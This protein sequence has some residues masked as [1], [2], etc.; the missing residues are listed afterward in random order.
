MIKYIRVSLLSFLLC[1]TLVGCGSNNI[2]EVS[3]DMTDSFNYSESS[4]NYA[5]LNM[6]NAASGVMENDY[7]FYDNN[8]E[9]EM[10]ETAEIKNITDENKVSSKLIRTINLSY[11][12]E[13]NNIQQ[14]M[15]SM[16]EKTK[17][18]GGYAQDNSVNQYNS[19]VN[20]SLVLRIPNDKADEFLN[21]VNGTKL[22]LK[23]KSDNQEDVTLTWSE[24]DTKI[25]VLEAQRDKYLSYIDNASSVEEILAVD[26]KLQK[27]ITD[28][29]VYQSKMKVLNDRINYTT[30]N[31]DL[32]YTGKDTETIEAKEGFWSRLGKQF[33]DS[34]EG[35]QDS[36]IEAIGLLLSAIVPII[37]IIIFIFIFIWIIKMFIWIFRGKRIVN[38]DS[39]SKLKEFRFKFFKKK[40]NKTEE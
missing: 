37:T 39:N 19:S 5:N 9:E 1:L 40:E 2:S 30:I 35:I 27:V 36:I 18:L 34:L 22:I 4:K 13:E 8:V 6:V 17:N 31:I 29:E 24:I 12:S 14:I 10:E 16:V 32:D 28:L 7:S 11:R 23:S 15:D 33:E 3:Y 20:G 38:K 25:H 21:F 26:E